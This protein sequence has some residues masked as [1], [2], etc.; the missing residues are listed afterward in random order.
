MANKD[1]KEQAQLFTSFCLEFSRRVLSE[2]V[3]DA[4]GNVLGVPDYEVKT[5]KNKR[6]K[7]EYQQ[8][9]NVIKTTF[10]F[11]LRCKFESVLV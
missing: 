8:R 9:N 1:Q 5:I 7:S 11:V 2:Q 4:L 3:V 6:E 10:K